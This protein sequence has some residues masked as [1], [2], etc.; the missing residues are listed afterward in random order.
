MWAKNRIVRA[1][2]MNGSEQKFFKRP[3]MISQTGG[4]G[5]GRFTQGGDRLLI[6]GKCK[7]F[8]GTTEMVVAAIEL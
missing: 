3:N 6:W 2:W 4:K 8:M 7:R 5:G 1:G